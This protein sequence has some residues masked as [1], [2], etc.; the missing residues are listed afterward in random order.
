[1]MERKHNSVLCDI[2]EMENNPKLV[3]SCHGPEAGKMQLKYDSSLTN[4]ISQ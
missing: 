3:K 2:K 1:M 4:K